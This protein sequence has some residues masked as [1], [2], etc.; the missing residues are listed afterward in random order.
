M[1]EEGM[2]ESI[3]YRGGCTVEIFNEGKF[4]SESFSMRHP[5]MEYHCAEYLHLNA[6]NGYDWADKANMAED[7]TGYKA[8]NLRE[9]YF[10]AS[11]NPISS[12]I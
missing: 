6:L 2:V 5:G 1:L 12:A 4:Q 7:Y 10:P 9:T 8:I 3:L 11:W